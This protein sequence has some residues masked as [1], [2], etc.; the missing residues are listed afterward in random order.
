MSKIK[1]LALH[2]NNRFPTKSFSS[3]RYAL[4]MLELELQPLA[5]EAAYA[6]HLDNLDRANI[7]AAIQNHAD[8]FILALNNAVS[9]LARLESLNI[10]EP[11]E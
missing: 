4:A 9:V 6:S 11:K 2:A 10:L 5:S 3:A 7:G 1:R 8:S